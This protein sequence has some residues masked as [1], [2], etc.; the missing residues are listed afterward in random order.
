MAIE[1]R[2][3]ASVEEYKALEWLQA[4]IWGTASDIVPVPLLVTMAKEGGVVLIALDE[5]K[6]V[7]FA[8]GFPALAPDGRLK[9]ASH[10]AGVLQAYQDR[11]LG[12]QVKLAQREVA[13]AKGFALV[14]WTFDPLQGRNGAFNLRKLGAVCKTYLPNLYGDMDDELNRGLPSDRFQVDWWL[15]S[16]H[17]SQRLEGRTAAP[18]LAKLDYPILNAAS[19]AEGEL[20]L[21]PERFA[22]PTTPACLVE[23]PVDLARLKRE[24]PAAALRWRLQTRQI[25]ETAF[26]AGYTAVDLLR[27][28]GRNYYLLQKD[29]TLGI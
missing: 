1:I 7:G 27:Y 12:Y 26:E 29:W 5:G 9:L 2:K 22:L 17:V 20:A 19:Q 6:P 4:E 15:A 16:P 3:P 18:D 23:I 13:L 11:G 28:E 14:T 21:P 10:Q 25:F 8:F 24:V